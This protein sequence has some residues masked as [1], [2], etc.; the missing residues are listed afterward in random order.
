MSE[1]QSATTAELDEREAVLKHPLAEAMKANPDHWYLI[2]EQADRT[3]VS[4]S[5]LEWLGDEPLGIPKS[6][7]LSFPGSSSD[8]FYVEERRLANERWYR[9]L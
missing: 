7:I 6:Y 2:D 9:P 5:N 4:A 1:I 8:P 3:R